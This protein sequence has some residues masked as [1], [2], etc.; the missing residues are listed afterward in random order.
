MLLMLSV[1]EML[2]EA[3]GCAV[4]FICFKLLNTGVFIL[5]IRF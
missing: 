4:R 1:S 5:Q 2:R 3:K